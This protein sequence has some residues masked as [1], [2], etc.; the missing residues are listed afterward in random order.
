MALLAPLMMVLLSKWQASL[1]DWYIDPAV[2]PMF[3]FDEGFPEKVSRWLQAEEI[4][5]NKLILIVDKDCVCTKATLRRLNSF[6][7]ESQVDRGLLLFLEINDLP[8][9]AQQFR[10][11]IPSTPT[12]LAIK[13]SALTYAGPINSGGFCTTA[14]DAVIGV[15]SLKHLTWW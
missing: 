11:D 15:S 10:E 8:E 2:A 9:S 12:L 6:L 5:G 1:E 7:N 3:G 4:T 14:V 13:N